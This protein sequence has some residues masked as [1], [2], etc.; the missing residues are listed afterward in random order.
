MRFALFFLILVFI[1][2]PVMAESLLIFREQIKG[3]REAEVLAM[4]EASGKYM[5]DFPFQ[6][7]AFDLNGDG[8]DEWI[9]RQ[10]RESGCEPNASCTYL[11]LG[12]SEKKPII[13]GD[14]SARKIE[15]ADQKTYGVR[16]LHVYN[17]RNDDFA[18]TS[19]VWTPENRAF[20]PQQ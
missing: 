6:I 15:L 2:L 5:P 8:V 7:A 12:L 16:N 9:F 10:D 20:L 19:Y 18:Y 14:I 3:P 17:D 4:L 13:L 11:I 1:P